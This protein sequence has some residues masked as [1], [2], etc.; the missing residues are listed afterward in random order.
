MILLRITFSLVLILLINTP[1]SA[2]TISCRSHSQFTK[3]INE[4]YF[5]LISKNENTGVYL[6]QYSN[7]LNNCKIDTVSVRI[8]ILDG[9][10]KEQCHN[11]TSDFSMSPSYD[12]RC[13]TNDDIYP[14][15]ESCNVVNLEYVVNRMF[16]GCYQISLGLFNENERTKKRCDIPRKHYHWIENNLTEHL[17]RYPKPIISVEHT[18]RHTNVSFDF[19]TPVPNVTFDLEM[20]SNQDLINVSDN[21]TEVASTKYQCLLSL[22]TGNNT[23]H[24]TLTNPHCQCHNGVYFPQCRWKKTLVKPKLDS[25]SSAPVIAAGIDLLSRVLIGITC[26]MALAVCLILFIFRKR[27]NLEKKKLRKTWLRSFS[28][29]DSVTKDNIDELSVTGIFLVYARDCE[30]FM[31]AMIHLQ[32]YLMRATGLPVYNLFDSNQ[33]NIIS[34]SPYE[35][36]ERHIHDPKIRVVL[37]ATRCSQLMYVQL[38]ERIAQPLS[39]NMQNMTCLLYKRPHSMDCMIQHAIKLLSGTVNS[40][41][42]YQKNFVCQLLNFPNEDLLLQINPYKRYILPGLLSSLLDDMECRQAMNNS[43]ENEKTFIASLNHL[44]TYVESHPGYLADMLK[45]TS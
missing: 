7:A 19:K 34:R 15:I 23:I 43:T 10:S 45:R 36:V 8:Y 11:L 42:S 21:C 40:A 5:N 37:V 18:T 17:I 12:K 29:S 28:R 32:K 31:E 44:S 1:R 27:R 16:Q 25:T 24:F 38:L 26:A 2:S 22:Q 14:S 13:H 33:F 41:S 39:A 20:G 9:V 6:I 4:T 30:P 35:W 3:S